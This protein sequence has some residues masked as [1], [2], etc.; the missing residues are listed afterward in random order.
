MSKKKSAGQANVRYPWKKW[1]Q[2]KRA[3]TLRQGK[4]FDCLP[5]S[6]AQ[7]MRNAGYRYGYRVS[8][9]VS[10]R[11]VTFQSTREKV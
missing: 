9:T 8:I 11:A 3:L 4:D 10:D 6:F 5:H 2:R 7:Q 1:L